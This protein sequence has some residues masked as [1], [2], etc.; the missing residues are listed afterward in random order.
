ME[1]SSSK[2]IK[3]EIVTPDRGVVREEVEEISTPGKEGYLGILPGHAPLLSELQPGELTYKK[4]G[5]NHYLAINGGFAEV[6]PYRVIILTQAAE[7]SN[8]VDRQRAEKARQRAEERLA[9]FDDSTVD[10]QRARAALARA[11]TRLHVSD[12]TA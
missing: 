2:P 12:R 8:E 10:F 3:L 1:N 9:R 7:R 4:S 11:V 5:K 6:L